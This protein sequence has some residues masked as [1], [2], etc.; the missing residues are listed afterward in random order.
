M[1][2]EDTPRSA[3]EVLR[4]DHTGV[5]V[6]DIE[7]AVDW[8]V[9][10]LGLQVAD[11]WENAETAMAWAHLEAPGARIELVQRPGLGAHA[12]NLAGLHHLAFVVDDCAAATDLLVARGAD[13]VFPPSYFDRHDMDWSFVRDPFGIILE[14]VSYRATSPDV[15]EPRTALD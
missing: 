8:Y 5:M 6:D 1:I 2:E 4:V 15:P 12:G 7:A 3:I 14:L 10:A 13:V 9:G 11:R